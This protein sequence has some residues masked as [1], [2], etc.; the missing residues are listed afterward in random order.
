MRQLIDKLGLKKTTLAV[1]TISIIFSL[2]VT[3][4]IWLLFS[5]LG[6]NLN[7]FITLLMGIIVPLFAAPFILIPIIYLIMQINQLEME[8]RLLATYDELT[9]CLNR[10]A[11]FEQ[12]ESLINLGDRNSIDSCLMMID[13]D[14]FKLINDRYGHSSGDKVIASLGSIF[15]DVMRKSDIVG[16][17][18]GEE[19]ALFLH[20]T[21]I[22]GASRFA[23]RLHESISLSVIKDNGHSINYTISIGLT[24]LR[25]GT[26]LEDALKQADKA[27]YCA[28]NNG[29]NQTIF[30]NQSM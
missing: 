2:A 20:Q 10:R 15:I 4:M 16:R 19:F 30:Y 1:M 23:E 11:F 7:L 21:S 14:K 29:R 25:S 18:G 9:G 5:L 17:I 13:I 12:S 24:Q 28:K 3:L 26:S 27:L 8:M 22:E 6:I